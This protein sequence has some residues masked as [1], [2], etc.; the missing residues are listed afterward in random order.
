MNT[1]PSSEAFFGSVRTLIA[2][3]ERAGAAQAAEELRSG[4]DCLNGLTDGW[5]LFMESLERVL[6]EQGT[7]LAAE[8]R[9]AL[10]ALLAQ[11]RRT[12]FRGDIPACLW[13]RF[14][15]RSFPR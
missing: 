13:H 10:Q 7:Q 4:F 8:H 14:R 1:C 6:D 11:V 3:L 15:R 9:A 12:V 5:A 2:Q